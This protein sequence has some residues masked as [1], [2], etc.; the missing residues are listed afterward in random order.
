MAAHLRA[1]SS[2]S[3]RLVRVEFLWL[4]NAPSIPQPLRLMLLLMLRLMFRLVCLH[5]RALSNPCPSI[6]R[7]FTLSS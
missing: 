6:F 3:Y 2:S 4:A 5:D 1:S 7:D